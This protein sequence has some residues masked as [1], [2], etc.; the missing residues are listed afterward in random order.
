MTTELP[1]EHD[2]H[3][4]YRLYTRAEAAEFLRI[5]PQW[6]TT[7][8]SSGQVY[9]IKSGR[10][11][12]YPRAALTAYVRGERFVDSL[13]GDDTTTWPPTPSVFGMLDG[14]DQ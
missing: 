3:D 6:L 8:T 2:P 4:P 11:R 13:E 12:L 9:S 7:L 1:V 5:T 10:R 14:G